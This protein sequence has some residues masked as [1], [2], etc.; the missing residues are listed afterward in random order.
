MECCGRNRT[1]I[2]RGQTS[3]TRP[4]PEPKAEEG[5]RLKYTGAG[6]IVVRGPATGRAYAFSS[7][8]AVQVD[9]RDSDALRRTR[10]FQ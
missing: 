1:K 9:R 6:E 10:L 8:A 4:D 3:M 2:A 5:V 7:G